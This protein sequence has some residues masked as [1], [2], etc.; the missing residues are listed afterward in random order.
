MIAFDNDYTHD[1]E[2][3]DDDEDDDAEHGDNNDTNYVNDDNETNVSNEHTAI[4]HTKNCQTKN[5]RVKIMKS[6]R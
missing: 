5:L 1:A 3:D 2:D 6:L 4:F